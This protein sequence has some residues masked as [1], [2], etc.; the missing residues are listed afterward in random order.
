MDIHSQ[1]KIKFS[2]YF[3]GIILILLSIA[4]ILSF[5]ILQKPKGISCTLEAKLCPDGSTV[6]RIPPNCEFAPC[7]KILTTPTIQNVYTSCYSND[8]C[9]LINNKYGVDCCGDNNC[10]PVDYSQSSWIA[11]NTKWQAEQI[12]KLCI[13]DRA[14]PNCL[15]RPINENFKAVCLN[16]TCQKVPL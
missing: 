3:L 7:L 12:S 2:P 10:Q 13:T 15:P 1:A 5:K 6:G 9:L 11:V 4:F 16:G 8:D 14:C